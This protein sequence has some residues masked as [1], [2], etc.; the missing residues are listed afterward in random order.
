MSFF[1]LDVCNFLF[2]FFYRARQPHQFRNIRIFT[3]ILR[4]YPA[5]AQAVVPKI[6]EMFKNIDKASGKV[7]GSS[8]SLA[9][10]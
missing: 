9:S 5:C 1:S 6:A 8:A 2:I 3:D 7:I 10:R 4:K